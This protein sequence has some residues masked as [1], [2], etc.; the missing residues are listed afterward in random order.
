VSKDQGLS[1]ISSVHLKDA[2]Y[3]ALYNAIANLDLAPGQAISENML[4]AEL[5]VSK[6]PIRAAL[7]RL[8]AEGL[9][10]TVPF[11]GTFVCPVDDDDVHDLIDLR[12]VLEVAAVNAAC[13]RA[14]DDQVSEL[15]VVARRAGLEEAGGSHGSALREIGDFHE[16][17]VQMSGNGR[18]VSAFGALTGP[19]KR[20]R[21]LSGA[22]PDSIGESSEEHAAIVEAIAD[23]DAERAGTLVRN[24]LQRVLDLYRTSRETQPAVE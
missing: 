5:G 14:S 20:I 1:R 22:Q 3:E 23:H 4:V 13:E 2:A 16:R 21:A 9:V 24:H 12:I 7:G 18:L 11:K 10:E 6:T 17:L 19:L 15:M 8:E